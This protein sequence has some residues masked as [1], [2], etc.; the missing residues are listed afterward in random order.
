MK[1]YVLSLISILFLTSTLLAQSGETPP[2]SSIIRPQG[3]AETAF[4]NIGD[5]QDIGDNSSG[6]F[7]PS[8][9]Q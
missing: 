6:N 1:Y 8:I 5:G 9:L 2:D 7:I 3:P 4:L